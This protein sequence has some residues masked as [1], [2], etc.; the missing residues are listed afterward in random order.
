[1]SRPGN[2]VREIDIPHFLVSLL[3]RG[4]NEPLTPSGDGVLASQLDDPQELIA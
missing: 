2:G 3:H 4:L 1:V